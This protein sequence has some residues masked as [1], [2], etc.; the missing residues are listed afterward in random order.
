MYLAPLRIY[1]GHYS[2]LSIV[3]VNKLKHSFSAG[4]SMPITKKSGSS[5]IGGSMN[6]NGALL[7]QA[8]H[9]GSDSALSQIVRLVE[10]AQTSKAPIQ[11]V[12]YIRK[13]HAQS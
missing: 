9:V 6:L 8:T 13:Y 3:C 7:M 1:V 5:V 12:R 4:E 11:Q 2:R 10:E